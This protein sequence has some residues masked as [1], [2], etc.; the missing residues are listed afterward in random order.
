MAVV[1]IPFCATAELAPPFVLDETY[2]DPNGIKSILLDKSN[3][4]IAGKPET[5]EVP[6]VGPVRI[7]VFYVVGTVRYICNAFPVVQSDDKYD[8]AAYSAPFDDT[9]DNTAP[10]C[11]PT[12]SGDALGWVTASG[13]VHIEQSIGGSCCMGDIPQIESVT[14]EDLAVANNL[15]SAMAPLCRSCGEE[16]KRIVKWRG[17]VVI[18][19]VEP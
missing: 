18:T 2:S 12:T 19:T 17:C 5:V 10:D 13:C 8:V 14:V 6:D 15:T 4:Q 11:V 16:E 3:V 1:K 7:C 9:T